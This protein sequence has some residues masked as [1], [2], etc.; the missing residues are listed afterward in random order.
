MSKFMLNVIYG[1]TKVGVLKANM[2][3]RYIFLSSI[4]QICTS[5]EVVAFD[6]HK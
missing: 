4:Y 3:H 6:D 5:E 2:V 1:P